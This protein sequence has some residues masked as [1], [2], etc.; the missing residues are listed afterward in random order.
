MMMAEVSS[1]YKEYFEYLDRIYKEAIEYFT[2]KKEMPDPEKVKFFV[3]M[4]A[5]PYFY[6]EQEKAKIQGSDM[7]EEARRN[8]FQAVKKK[9][10]LVESTKG[11][12]A[13]SKRLEKDKFRELAAKM[14]KM[15]FTYDSD[16]NGFVE[17]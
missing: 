1:G 17:E 13:P 12:W 2:E 16:K 14:N 4:A 11:I 9:Y 10:G 5:R 3:S 8:W 7:T 15:G 6:W